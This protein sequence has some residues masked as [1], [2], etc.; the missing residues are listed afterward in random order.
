M[1]LGVLFHDIGKLLDYKTPGA[2][3]SLG[4]DL[5]LSIKP[6][7]ISPD[8]EFLTL[9]LITTHDFLGRL[10]RGLIQKQFSVNSPEFDVSA[11]PTYSAAVDPAEIVRHVQ[12]IF[13]IPFDGIGNK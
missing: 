3:A 7:W 11:V 6:P 8:I 12:K 2:H 4:G 10:A 1:R 9:H 5:F 13:R